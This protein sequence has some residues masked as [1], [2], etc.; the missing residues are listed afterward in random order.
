MVKIFGGSPLASLMLAAP[1]DEPNWFSEGP[2]LVRLKGV[3][4]A[5]V[6]SAAFAENLAPMLAIW[7]TYAECGESSKAICIDRSDPPT[8]QW[9]N[10]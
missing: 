7:K 4:A 1:S 9:T 5:R 2:I 8:S 10:Y 6:L 3:Q